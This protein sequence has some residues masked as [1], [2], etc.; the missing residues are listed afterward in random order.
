MY[1][2]P[3][4]CFQIRSDFVHDYFIPVEDSIVYEPE[5]YRSTDYLPEDGTDETGKLT[6][7]EYRSK[8]MTSVRESFSTEEA[9]KI[10]TILGIDWSKS[11]F[12]V[13]QYKQGLNVELEHGRID[14][15]T[16]VTGDDPMMTG[17]IALAHLKEFPDYYTRLSRM[18]LEAREYWA[19]K[20][21]RY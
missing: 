14:P 2:S 17:K 9:K 15:Q 8:D 5:V 13:E 1:Q 19:G 21:I 11:S 20:P 7:Y 12:D 18:E 6:D 4:C 10:G 3:Y 16:N